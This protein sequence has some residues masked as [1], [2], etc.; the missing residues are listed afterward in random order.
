VVFSPGRPELKPSPG[1]FTI[2]LY[3]GHLCTFTEELGL[4][5]PT[6]AEIL[7]IAGAVELIGAQ[8]FR[9]A[10]LKDPRFPADR[11]IAEEVQSQ[12]GGAAR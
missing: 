3:C 2:C 5:D 11:K 8:K 10:I 6:D 4:R 12:A 9:A 7:E 1:D